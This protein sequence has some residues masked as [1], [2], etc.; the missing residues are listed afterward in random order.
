MS[1]DVPSNQ[2]CNDADK[3]GG[4]MLICPICNTYCDFTR[5]SQSCLY[6]KIAYIFDNFGAVLYG[7]V[8]AIWATLFLEVGFVGI[9]IFKFAVKSWQ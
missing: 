2:I 5:L 9:L 8:V 4:A 1:S 3:Q 7:A 6:S